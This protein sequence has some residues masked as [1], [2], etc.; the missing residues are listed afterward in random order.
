MIVVRTPRTSCWPRLRLAAWGATVL[1]VAGALLPA[2]VAGQADPLLEQQWHLK[3]RSAEP[4]GANVR[5]VWPTTRGSGVVIGIVDDG[6]QHTHPD[7][8]PNYSSALSFDFN[9][10]DSDP[11]PNTSVDHHGTAVAG[12]AAARGDNG[13]GVSGAAPLATLAGLRLISAAATDAQEADALGH[14]GNAIHISSNSWGPADDGK[15]LAGPGPLTQSAIA[16]AITQG[17]SG[18]GR[19]FTWAAGNGKASQDNCNFDG[20]ANSRYVIAV[21]ALADTGTQASY[22]EPCAA[23]LVTAPSSGGSRGVT[24]TDLVGAPGYTTTDYTSTFGGTSSATPLVSG[25]IALMLARNQ[26]L[27]WRD[28]QHILVESAFKI[29]PGDSGWTTGE[30]AH[31]EKFGFGLVDAQAA[32]NLATTWTNVAAEASV[33]AVTRT[34]NVTIPDNN[35][36]GVSDN[37]TIASSFSNFTVERVEVVFD[38][39]HTYRGDLEVTLTSPAGVSSRLATVRND[40]GD[41]FASWRFGSVRHWGEVAAGTW[42]LKVADR[43]A[44]DVGTWKSWKLGI[45][46]TQSPPA[47]SVTPTGTTDFGSVTVDTSTDRD[48]TVKNT[49][50]PTLTGS[51]STSAPFSIVSGGSFSLGA[52]ASQTV[53]VRFSPTSVTTFSGNVSF[54]SNGGDISRAV[55]GT[56]K[57]VQFSLTVSK[58]GNGTGTVTSSPTGIS[59]GGDCSESVD[60]GTSVT[61]TATPNSGSVFTGWSGGGCSG[62]GTCTVTVSAATTI[63]ATFTASQQ[64]FTL[65]VVRKGS[66]SGTVTSSPSGINCGSTCSASYLVNTVVTLTATPA[67]GATFK[68]WGGA[69][70]G[71]SCTVTLNTNKTVDAVFAKTFTD[72]SLVVGNTVKAVHFTELREAIDRLRAVNGLEAFAWTDPTLAAGSTAVKRLHLTELRTALRC[73]YDK[74]GLTAPA[75]TDPSI[76]AKQTRIKAAH[77]NQLRDAVRDLE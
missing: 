46:G 57:A 60:S 62:T 36:T 1:W 72:A 18:K 2:R 21:G 43:V 52:G 58:A 12:V 31:N 56:G 33:P 4:A 73:T 66:A 71:A 6:L 29:N 40:S 30:F 38:A 14:Q 32:V 8:Q 16:T 26:A 65:T 51:A 35:A 39:T 37:V 9:F 19:I 74:A 15:T 17:R 42:T 61:L 3:A 75:Y 22:S 63:T 41:N 68:Q 27:T 47:I 5:A 59:C 28:V 34:L 54:T 20:Y 11:S 23:M 76:V 45:Y 50:G 44:Q 77:L 7:L 10:N 48:F 67:A 69:C 55:T 13:I 53:V 70:S 24:T 49:G 25:V 64:M